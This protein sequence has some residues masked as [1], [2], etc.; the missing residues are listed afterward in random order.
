MGPAGRLQVRVR[1]VHPHARR[2]GRCGRR[3]Q[4][5]AVHRPHQPQLCRHSGIRAPALRRAI[6][7][8]QLVGQRQPM[9]P[10]AIQGHGSAH[11]RRG[12][13]RVPGRRVRHRLVR[14]G[15]AQR[16]RPRRRRRRLPNL[17]WC[18]HRRAHLAQLGAGAVDVGVD[19]GREQPVAGERAR[20]CAQIRRR[21]AGPPHLPRRVHLHTPGAPHWRREDRRS[22][23]RRA[24]QRSTGYE[25]ARIG[26][27]NLHRS[28]GRPR[29]QPRPRR[30]QPAAGRPQLAVHVAAQS[31]AHRP[32]PAAKQH[33][34]PSNEGVG[35]L[36]RRLPPRR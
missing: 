35:G 34:R 21:R 17:R 19:G 25:D 6:W 8:A 7:C 27:D 14:D 18:A 16:A 15:S 9:A 26:H 29:Y 13:L 30:H 24:R 33:V 36:S 23:A 32:R 2:G 1:R 10:D 22:H 31:V 4:A 28:D 3:R 5:G 20:L 12:E 11:G